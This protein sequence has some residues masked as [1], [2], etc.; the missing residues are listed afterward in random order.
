MMVFLGVGALLPAILAG[1]ALIATLVL[2]PGLFATARWPRAGT[3]ASA[4][5]VVSLGFVGWAAFAPADADHPHLTQAF[6]VAGPAEA[7]FSRS[8]EH[9][10]ELQSLMRYSYAVLCL[11]Q[12]TTHHSIRIQIQL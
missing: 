9:T 11:T 2:F 5:F 1:L 10:S 4:L 12:K 8:E 7:E 3:A 6:Y